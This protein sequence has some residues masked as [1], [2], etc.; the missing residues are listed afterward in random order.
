MQAGQ[1]RA[2]RKSGKQTIQG[3]KAN[4]AGWQAGQD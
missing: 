2:G 1:G 3:R 4:T